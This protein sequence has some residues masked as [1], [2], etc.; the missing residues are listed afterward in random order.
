MPHMPVQHMTI[1]YDMGAPHALS[2]GKGHRPLWQ[3][4]QLWRA[5]KAPG[6]VRAETARWAREMASES[7]TCLS[8]SRWQLSEPPLE[9]IELTRVSITE[10]HIYSVT[11]VMTGGFYSS[12]YTRIFKRVREQACK[13]CGDEMI[14]L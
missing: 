7:A 12:L 6:V 5:V 8:Q 3:L 4:W 11:T 1:T 14:G 13:N 2:S 9:S 10:H